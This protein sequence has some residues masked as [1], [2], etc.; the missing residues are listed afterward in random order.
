MVAPVGILFR[1]FLKEAMSKDDLQTRLKEAGY[2]D[3]RG[4]KGKQITVEVKGDRE[5]A[6]KDIAKKL[7][8]KYNPK[9]GSSSVGRVETKDGWKIEVKHPKGKGG[10]GAGA[11]VTKMAECAQCVY[12]AA[13]WYGKG[14]YTASTFRKVTKYFDIDDKLDRIINDLPEDWRNSS[15]VIAD[16]IENKFR[17]KRYKFHRGSR[18][19]DRLENHWKKLNKVE[20]EFSNLN[21][22]SPADIYMVTA[23][24]ENIDLTQA[25]TLVELNGMMLDAYM[26]G[27]I[28]GVSLKKVGRTARLDP[29]NIDK[30]RKSYEYTGWT[31]GKKG[32]F[33]SNDIYIRYDGGEIQFRTFGSTW[34]GEIKGQFAN[35]GK[36]SGGP[37]ASIMKRHT[38]IDF[39][40]QKEL[41]QRTEANVKKFLTFHNYIEG[42]NMSQEEFVQQLSQKDDTFFTS[43]IMG[44]QFLYHFLKQND[45]KK[46]DIVSA[47]LGYA[48]SESEMS[49]PYL[50]A[51]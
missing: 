31:S 37:I 45:D 39:I 30:S 34:Q 51:H 38:G 22:W 3:I 7:D 15:I 23:K 6:L 11:D 9:G 5:A 12:L 32:F 4:V 47:I 41:A 2:K 35:Q 10:S 27:D 17:T 29:K 49:G 40:P 33:L 24:G 43:M 8:A 36:I 25:S 19:V 1:T 46:R 18:W 20:K 26:S 50:K 28:I 48:A 16:A 44:S 21:K 42:K 13:A 14:D